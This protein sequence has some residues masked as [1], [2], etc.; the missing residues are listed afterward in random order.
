MGNG[1]IRRVF[2]RVKKSAGI[3]KVGG[4]HGLRHA[5]ATHQLENGMA[6][7]RLQH[8]LGHNDLHSTLRYVHWLPSQSEGKTEHHDLIEQLGLNHG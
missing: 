5:Y 1:T 3:E 7:H 4:I 6:I 2:K 8:Q